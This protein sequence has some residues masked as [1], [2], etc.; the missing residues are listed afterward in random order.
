MI[1]QA[2]LFMKIHRTILITRPNHDL[3]TTYLYYWSHFI[4][5]EAKNKNIPIFDLS[6]K[7]ATKKILTSYVIKNTP[8]FIH[9]NGH[10]NSKSITGYN[11][12]IL[13]EANINDK[14]LSKKLS[15]P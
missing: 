5:K 7:K 4:I 3:I 6:G 14:L 13:I 9:F 8:G 1:W 15:M 10:G 2:E 11:N 12:E